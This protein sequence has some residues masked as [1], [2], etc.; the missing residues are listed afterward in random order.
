MPLTEECK[1]Q[2]RTKLGFCLLPPEETE[3]MITTIERGFDIGPIFL[4][5]LLMTVEEL[6]IVLDFPVTAQSLLL[7]TMV[8]ITERQKKLGN[9]VEDQS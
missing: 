9:K 7:S 4:E 6:A 5:R 1:Q 2:I 8:F 3:N